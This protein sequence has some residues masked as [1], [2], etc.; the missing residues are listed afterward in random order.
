MPTDKS[1]Y[2]I[3]GLGSPCVDLLYRV[4]DNFLKELSLSKGN[5]KKVSWEIFSSVL[6]KCAQLEYKPFIRT[7]GSCSN[8]IKGLA[9]L[10]NA[11]AFLGKIGQDELANFYKKAIS[12]FKIVPLLLTSSVPTTQIA[13]FVTE[14]RERTFLAFPGAGYQ[15]SDTDLHPKM[16]ENVRL[17]HIEGYLLDKYSVVEKA[18]QLAK[19][20]G[21]K[22]SLDLGC[23]DI[24]QR[25]QEDII[26]LLKAYVDIVF[27]NEEETKALLGLAPEEG[28]TLLSSY[29]RVAVVLAGKKGC[30]VG[31]KETAFHSPAVLVETVDTTGAGDLFA[32]GF[33]HGYLN[34]YT[35]EQC[36]WLGNLLGG[37]VVTV[38]GAEIPSSLW[39]SL[40]AQIKTSLLHK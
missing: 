9:S 30:W 27:A 10:D 39:P 6:K 11:T 22:V 17:I 34:E 24:V 12:P 13:V 25:Y 15:I 36:A 21:A 23:I 26:R 19:A 29:C 14:D 31:F 33:L 40:K 7:G 8:T 38:I 16:F 5:E 2:H 35:L 20:A 28:C 3:L 4:D 37:T 1:P 18:M 32:C